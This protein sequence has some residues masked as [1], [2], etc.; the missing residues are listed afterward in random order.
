MGRPVRT[1]KNGLRLRLAVLASV[2]AFACATCPH[3]LAQGRGEL[4]AVAPDSPERVESLGRDVERAESLR[5]IKDMEALYTQYAA[6]GLWDEVGRLLSDDVELWSDGRMAFKGRAD[7]V[8]HLKDQFSSGHNGIALG[9]TRREFLMQPV[10]IL[11][12]DGKSATGRWERMIWEGQFGGQNGGTASISGGMQVNDYVKERGAWKLS[13][14]HFYS[15][16]AGPYETGFTATK[17]SLPLV[18]YPFTPGQAGR[19]VPGQ[20]SGVDRSGPKLSLAE[21]ERRI[22]RAEDGNQIRNLQNAYGYYIDRKM[23]SDVIDLFTPDGALEIAGQGVWNGTKSIRRALEANGPE[24]LKRGEANDH[25]QMDTVVTV[26]PDGT[27]SEAR[28]IDV[29]MLSPGRGKAYWSTAIFL[30]RYLKGQDGKW[31]I[32]EMRLFPKMKADYALGWGK[33][34][35]IDPKPTGAAAPDKPSSADDA[36]IVSGA[37]PAF[38]FANPG[39]G[40][41]AVYP[42]GARV[43]G[44]A[45]LLPPPPPVSGLPVTGSVVQRLAAAHR[46]MDR[47]KAYDAIE[48]VSNSFGYYLDDT[49]WD[50]MAESFAVNGTRPQGPGFYVGHKHILEAMTQTHFDGP[51]SATNPRDHLNMHNRLQP[52]ID[53]APDGMTGKL[54]TRLLLYHVSQKGQQTSTFSTGMYPNETFVKEGDVWKMDVGGEIDETYISSPSWT[55]GW[56]N[57]TDAPCPSRSGAG[58]AGWR[59]GMPAPQSGITN[60]IDFP[61]DVPR[62]LLDG[63]RWKA[64]QTTNWPDIK[65]MWFAYRNPVSGRTPPNYCP[66]ILK[67]GGY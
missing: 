67:C 16:Y 6:F 40:K 25:I 23:W 41:A 36:P 53:V 61:P 27:E 12:Y 34:N 8:K 29:G 50:Q 17:P 2:L 14:L 5:Q 31:R 42:D 11:S 7:F 9:Q 57:W 37:I 49:M 20:P 10:V 43:V 52:V 33:S 54:R 58:N 38:P 15:Q 39:S 51:P 1:A 63:Y 60:T 64:M 24:G 44:T 28:G 32:R 19:P 45:R 30:N 26:S 13:R 4:L 66:D 65:P 48:N 46:A 62:T 59:P 56:A 18:P 21:S 55:E 22:A 35:I 3:A 47:V